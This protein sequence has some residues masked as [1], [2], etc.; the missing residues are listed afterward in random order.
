MM[1]KGLA[2][3]G[4]LAGVAILALAACGQSGGSGKTAT[5]GGGAQSATIT[6]GTINDEMIDLSASE[7]YGATSTVDES[8]VAPKPDSDKPEAKK[9][10]DDKPKKAEAK[11]KAPAP[12]PAKSDDEAGEE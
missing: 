9:S 2:M 1:I 6:E 8:A 11:S 7:S 4:I 3:R 12:A 5:G 10:A